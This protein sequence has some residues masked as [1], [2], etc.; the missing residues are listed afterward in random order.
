MLERWGIARWMIVRWRLERS[1]LALRRC[2]RC[3][4]GQQSAEANVRVE[5]EEKVAD[6]NVGI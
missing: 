6:G 1:R 3:R 5:G 4:L 2:Q